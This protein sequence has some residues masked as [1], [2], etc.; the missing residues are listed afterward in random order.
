MAATVGQ[1]IEF[2]KKF[3]SNAFIRGYE[4]EISGIIIESTK[5]SLGVILNNGEMIDE[6]INNKEKKS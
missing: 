6:R 5:K 2:L 4:G 3:P 1:A